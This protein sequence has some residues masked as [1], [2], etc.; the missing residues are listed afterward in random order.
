MTQ[1]AWHQQ[2]HTLILQGV[3]DQFTLLPFW[4]QFHHN[5]D[6]QITI[7]DVSTISQIDSAGLAMLT[8]FVNQYQLQLNGITTTLMTLIKLY[9]LQQVL[10]IK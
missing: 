5:W 7:L 3:L 10:N 6:Q 1:L 4:Q 8:Y 9:N 2:Q